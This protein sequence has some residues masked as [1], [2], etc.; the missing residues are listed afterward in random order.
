MRQR[1]LKDLEERL[2][3]FSDRLVD[4][5]AEYKGTWR[6]LQ[7]GAQRLFVELGCGKGRFLAAHGEADPAALFIGVE[8]QR[9]VLL[10]A[11]ET[12]QAREVENVRLVGAFLHSP[13]DF[14]APG[15][16]DGIY[17]NFCDPW[18]KARHAKRRLTNRRYLEAYRRVIR[19]GGFIEC[20][21]DNNDLYAFTLEEGEAC[22]L[23]IEEKTMDLHASACESRHYCT[24]Y[25][26][27]FRRLGQKIHY[28]KF[29]AE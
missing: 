24:E 6:Q 14:F 17:I 28:V 4:Q 25:E 23:K 22:G 8:G 18:P 19:P 3:G 20:K 15:E 13:E 12:L 2:A 9:S 29:I 27:K 16:L 7:P 11:C 21:T 10:R 26:E 5:P 1:R